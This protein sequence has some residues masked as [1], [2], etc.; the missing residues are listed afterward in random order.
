MYRTGDDDLLDMGSFFEETGLFSIQEAWD[1]GWN[2][3]VDENLKTH[4][5][6]LLQA[7]FK[8]R[9]SNLE[10]INPSDADIDCFKICQSDGKAS[11]A[12]VAED[13]EFKDMLAFFGYV[14][15]RVRQENDLKYYLYIEPI[16]SESAYNF[17]WKECK[18]IATT[19]LIKVVSNQ[20]LKTG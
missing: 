2:E 11:I 13:D 1:K 18:G 5:K 20:Y 15:K 19:S 9:F 14:T 8:K 7:Q 4:N 6:S 17:V 3:M 10:F 12:K 16:Y